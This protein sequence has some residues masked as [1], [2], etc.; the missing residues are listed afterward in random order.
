MSQK[1]RQDQIMQIL[2]NES[3]VTVRY[4]VDGSR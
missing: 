2:K 3:F 4:L 1:I